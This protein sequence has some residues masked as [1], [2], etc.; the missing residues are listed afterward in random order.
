M[1]SGVTAFLYVQQISMLGVHLP[2]ILV[3]K[4]INCLLFLVFALPPG[5]AAPVLHAHKIVFVD[6]KDFCWKKNEGMLEG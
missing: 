4:Y 3:C 5:F 6:I 2:I 1:T